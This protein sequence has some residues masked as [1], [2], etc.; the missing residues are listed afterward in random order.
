MLQ[1]HTLPH[2]RGK[3]KYRVGRG[4]ARRGNY[5][6]RGIKGQR[7]RSGGKGGLKLRGLKQ[8]MLAVPKKR[9]FQSA[10]VRVQIV[11]LADLERVFTD[12]ATVD[13]TALSA[14]GLIQSLR[15]PVKILGKGVLT[16]RLVVHAHAVSATAQEALRKAG[17][18]FQ[19]ITTPP[20]TSKRRSS[21]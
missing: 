1:Y 14:Q 2:R 13:R 3:K 17:G 6:G 11:N 10:N 8:S 16:K 15:H 9:G 20:K 18:E 5:S 19:Q 12:G 4:N 7:A 21:S